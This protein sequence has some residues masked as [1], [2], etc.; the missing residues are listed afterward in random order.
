M[1]AKVAALP[2][3]ERHRR[4]EEMNRIQSEHTERLED[5]RDALK[6]GWEIPLHLVE[7]R[8]GEPIQVLKSLTPEESKQA[9]EDMVK[10]R[11]AQIDQ[12][13]DSIQEQ[14]RGAIQIGPESHL[15]EPILDRQRREDIESRLDPLD[16]SD[17]VFVGYCDQDIP[18]Q[19]GLT[20]TLRT[21]L[22]RQ[23]LWVEEYIAKLPE[24]SPQHVAHTFGLCQVAVSLQA[25]NGKVY[26]SP[27]LYKIKDQKEFNTQLTL[28]LEKLGDMPTILS[29]DLIVQFNWFVGRVR[30]SLAGNLTRRVGN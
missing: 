28:R 27:D 20:V 3:E 12:E 23:S 21:L 11:D 4:L 8:G 15:Y 18:L 16:F 29:D 13:T 6:E 26:N 1:A 22:T 19:E 2:P 25:V 17:I 14:I 7:G 30:K 5:L 10:W 24:T 9:H